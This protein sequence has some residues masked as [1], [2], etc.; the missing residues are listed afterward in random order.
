MSY[1][2]LQSASFST[3]VNSEMVGVASAASGGTVS[4]T[5]AGSVSSTSGVSATAAVASGVAAGVGVASLPPQAANTHSVS[6]SSP[7]TS[8]GK[9]GTTSGGMNLVGDKG[10]FFT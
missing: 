5:T 3:T 8:Q 2:M 9:R 7:D 10:R 1:S 6:A 4:S